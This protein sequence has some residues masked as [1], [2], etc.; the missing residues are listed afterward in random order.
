MDISCYISF[1]Q[2]HTGVLIFNTSGV[3]TFIGIIPP[4]IPNAFPVNCTS[5]SMAD[6]DSNGMPIVLATFQLLGQNTMTKT[7]YKR[8]L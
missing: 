2:L 4:E 1:Y 7:T 8:K 3:E 6:F 5:T